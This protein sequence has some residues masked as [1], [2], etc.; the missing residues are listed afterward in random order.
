[1]A[2]TTESKNKQELLSEYAGLMTAEEELQAE[3]AEVQDLHRA[4]LSK[5]LN[6]KRDIILSLELA[7]SFERPQL[8]GQ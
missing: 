8:G 3:F 6:R 7:D 2:K 1:M 5:I 4:Q